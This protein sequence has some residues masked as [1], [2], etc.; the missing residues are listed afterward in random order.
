MTPDVDALSA[1]DWH[2]V[3]VGD[4]ASTVSRRHVETWLRT[5]GATPAEIDD[6]SLVASELAANVVQH[7]DAHELL[8]RLDDSDSSR[9][10]LE[11]VGGRNLLPAHL[12]DPTSW[13]VS[14][15]Q[16]THGRGLGIVRK[17]VDAV[18]VLIELDVLT[19]RCH[20]LRSRPA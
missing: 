15:P 3:A 1:P 11:V 16:D 6:L 17:V 20:R 7:G 8:V 19:I 2:R 14:R 4:Q 12:A 9:W 10:T 18:E 5:R 13:E